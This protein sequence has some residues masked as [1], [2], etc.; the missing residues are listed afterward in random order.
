MAIFEGV[1]YWPE[2]V[3]LFP[4]HHIALLVH[5]VSKG[6]SPVFYLGSLKCYLVKS[7]CYTSKDSQT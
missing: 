5:M 3:M 2:L 4:K 6:R 7:Q 1:E